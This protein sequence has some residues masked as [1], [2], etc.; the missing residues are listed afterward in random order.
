MTDPNAASM[1]E[2]EFLEQ[3]AARQ[4]P[5]RQDLVWPGIWLT[6][7]GTLVGLVIVVVFSTLEGIGLG[8]DLLG[9]A[10]SGYLVYVFLV[11]AIPSLPVATVL[12]AILGWLIANTSIG[13]TR[14]R[15]QVAGALLAHGIALFVA[16]GLDLILSLGTPAFGGGDPTL[17]LTF[18][19]ILQTRDGLLLAGLT[20]ALALV[21]GSWLGAHLFA[22]K[23]TMELS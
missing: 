10:L 1:T 15:A 23:R 13:T 17:G 20:V 16:S 9:M 4:L 5:E 12:G 3:L 7:M 18:H 8:R 19:S 21:G 22:R 11:F 2:A 6:I 14:R